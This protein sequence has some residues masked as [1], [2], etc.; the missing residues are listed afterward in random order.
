VDENGVVTGVS[1]GTATI[2]AVT[3]DGSNRRA[4]ITVKVG[5]HV[6][7]VHMVRE[8]AY[9]D[10][11]ETATAGATLEPKDAT[12]NHM[13]WVSSDESVVTANGKTNAKMHLKGVG[14]G[15][16]T[17]TG[18]TEDG[19]FQTSIH[20]TVGNFDHSLRLRDY[21]YNKDGDFWLAVRNDSD[22]TITRITA[23]VE[24]YKSKDRSELEINK[25]DGSNLVEVVWTGQLAP[26]ETTGTRHWKMMNYAAPAHMNK[27]TGR[28]T[29]VSF[30]INGD[31]I[32]TIRTS[33]RP[34]L[35]Y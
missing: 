1:R 12:N 10:L 27:T 9:I 35:E 19:G 34:I 4:R 23:T 17:V 8:N 6:T 30:Q 22:F 5:Q 29:L 33:N 31:W 28:I 2:N 21:G 24:L 15:E 18:T 7:G 3:A 11:H 26:G 25:K 13:T 32:K 14:Y 16:A 20:V